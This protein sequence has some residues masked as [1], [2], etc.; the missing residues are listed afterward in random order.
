M[1]VRQS[2]KPGVTSKTAREMVRK[3]DDEEKITVERDLQCFPVVRI[4][5]DRA[6]RT[7]QQKLS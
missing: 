1:V 5:E 2:S 3:R 6:M 7:N 4:K